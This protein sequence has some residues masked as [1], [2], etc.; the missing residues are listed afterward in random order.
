MSQPT[1][2]KALFLGVGRPERPWW[3]PHLDHDTLGCQLDYREVPLDGGRPKGLLTRGFL[4]LAIR[5]TRAVLAARRDGYRY[6]F[7]FENDWI[8]FIIAGLQTL[9]FWR[10]PRHVILQFIMREKSPAIQSRLKYAFLRWCYRSV[11]LVVVSSRPEGEYYRRVFGWPAHKVAFVPFHT[12]PAFV[13]HPVATDEPF[14]VAAGRTFRDYPTLIAAAAHGLDIPVTIVA[15][16]GSLGTD[17]PPAG[18]TARYDIPLPELIALMAKAAIVVLPLTEREISTG[19]SVLLEAMAMGKPVV[20]TRVNGT[21]DYIDHM[22]T[23]LLVPPGDSQA[24]AAAI[25]TLAR[26]AALRQRIGEAGRREVL[27]RFLPNHYAHG[28]ARALEELG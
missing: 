5:S 26:D 21:V 11:Y 27:E 23:G 14:A 13:K 2:A 12:D 28:V 4:H 8:T 7:S 16:K 10:R 15:G 19:Q 18:I 1:R 9:L 3:W 20:V 24:L 6:V 17:P 22:R 25:N